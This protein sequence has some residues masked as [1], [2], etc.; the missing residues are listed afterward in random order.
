[1]SRGIPPG[2]SQHVGMVGPGLDVPGGMTQVHRTW[3]RARAMQGVQVDYIETMSELPPLRW[4]LKNARCQARY[5]RK[6]L[7]GWRPDLIHVHVAD[8]TS[9]WRKLLYIEQAHAAGIPT[10]AHLHGAWM[11][12]FH[13]RSAANRAAIR[14]MFSIVDLVMPLHGRMAERVRQWAPGPVRVEVLYNPVVCEEFTPLPQPVQQP[15]VLMMGVLHERK[16]PFDLLRAAPE[17]LRRVP[18]ARFVF[19]GNGDLD[20]MR[21]LAQELGVSEQVEL[22]GW[23][24]GEEKLAAFRRAAVYCLPSHFENLPVS[25]IEAMAMGLPV[26]ATDVAGIP[27]E[28]VEGQTGFLVPPRRPEQLAARLSELLLDPALRARM[29]LAARQRALQL[30]DNEV[31]VERLVALWRSVARAR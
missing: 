10:V 1:M 30:F 22:L 15:L 11:E 2:L 21:R 8:G 25:I 29:G 3:M 14:R 9:F 31:V 12:D 17:I 5:A 4:A 18:D 27:E 26:V 7:F 13:D 28:V 23:V 24:A 16:G 19:G 20:G 6:L